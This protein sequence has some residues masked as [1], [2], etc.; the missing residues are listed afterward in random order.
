MLQALVW[1]IAPMAGLLYFYRPFTT[2]YLFGL[3]F[4]LLLFV[5]YRFALVP[6]E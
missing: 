3:L 6:G 5:P 4:Q 1:V 2:N